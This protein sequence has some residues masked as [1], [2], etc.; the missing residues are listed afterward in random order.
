[1]TVRILILASAAIAAACISMEGPRNGAASISVIGLPSPSVVKGDTMRD[2]LGNAAPLQILAYDASGHVIAGS[3]PTFFVLDSGFAVVDSTGMFVSTGATSAGV[4]VAATLGGLQTPPVPIPISVAPVIVNALTATTDTLCVSALV[5]NGSDSTKTLSPALSVIVKGADST[6]AQGFI[7]T[8]TL[9]YSPPSID[10]TPSAYVS[11]NTGRRMVRD[12][13]K[14]SGQTSRYVDVRFQKVA[15]DSLRSG[16]KIDTVGV[17]V[18]VRYRGTVLRG[19]PVHF[20]VPIRVR[21][22]GTCS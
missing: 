8:Y 7:A 11:D 15:S 2:S 5:A 21:V 17:D 12:T 14:S 13:T 3:R 22:T 20:V 18:V 10:T 1:M 9:S 19:S 6:A 16:L 4:R